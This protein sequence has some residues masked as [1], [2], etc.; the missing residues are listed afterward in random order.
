MSDWIMVGLNGKEV[1]LNDILVELPY[2]S[3]EPFEFKLEGY[4]FK[5]YPENANQFC[6]DYSS[7]TYSQIA[8][9]GAKS[10]EAL[11]DFAHQTGDIIEYKKK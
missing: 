7:D 4:T 3:Q 11:I 2:S 9:A 8:V 5:V 10:L 1:Y 6:M